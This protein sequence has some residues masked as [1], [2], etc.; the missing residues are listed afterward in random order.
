MNIIKYFRFLVGIFKIL[1]TLVTFFLLL[2]TKV[3]S[4]FNTELTRNN[5]GEEVSLFTQK[6]LCKEGLLSI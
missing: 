6:I 5:R 2:E 1:Y 3:A 4:I